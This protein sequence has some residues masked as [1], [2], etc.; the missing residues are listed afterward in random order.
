[1]TNPATPNGLF[2]AFRRMIEALDLGFCKL[3]RIQW[4][5]P[6]RRQCGDC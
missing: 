3:N 1:M 6:W 4:Q 2:A 5:A